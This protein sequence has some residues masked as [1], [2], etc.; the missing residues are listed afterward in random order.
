MLEATRIDGMQRALSA[1]RI[2][3]D[4]TSFAQAEPCHAAAL[5]GRGCILSGRQGRGRNA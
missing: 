2:G 3:H 5:N 4:L 1:V